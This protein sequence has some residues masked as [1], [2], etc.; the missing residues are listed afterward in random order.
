MM[1]ATTPC[2]KD[3]DTQDVLDII[4]YSGMVKSAMRGVQRAKEFHYT[5]RLFEDTLE[6]QINDFMCSKPGIKII[7]L[8]YCISHNQGMYTSDY[9]RYALLMYEIAGV[10]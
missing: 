7:A 2:T 1:T 10:E 8:Q 3:F 6:K 9:D 5:N 4:K